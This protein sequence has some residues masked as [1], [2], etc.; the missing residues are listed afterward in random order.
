MPFLLLFVVCGLQAGCHCPMAVSFSYFSP[1]IAT[2]TC[3]LYLSLLPFVSLVIRGSA[4]SN[5]NNDERT[6]IHPSLLPHFLHTRHAPIHDSAHTYTHTHITPISL[7]LPSFS[8]FHVLHCLLLLHFNCT[9]LFVLCSVVV[10]SKNFC[11]QITTC[12]PCPAT[13]T[14]FYF[15]SFSFCVPTLS[16]PF[17]SS[18]LSSLFSPPLALPSS[19]STPILIFISTIRLHHIPYSQTS[20]TTTRQPRSTWHNQS[21][22]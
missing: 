21:L 17:S 3:S 20:L 9:R 22:L 2:A 18:L 14:F 16:F 12:S 11:L 7:F 4:T 5:N 1:S 19:S 15:F 13:H 10:V 6:S 8:A